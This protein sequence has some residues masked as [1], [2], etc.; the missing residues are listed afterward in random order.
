MLVGGR[1]RR[2][3]AGRG[4]PLHDDA[5]TVVGFS[6]AASRADLADAVAAARAA[7]PGWSGTSAH[8][9]GRLLF[10]VAEAL[11]ERRDRLATAAAV[12]ADDV[13]TAVD[14]WL[15]YA[16]W[17]DK[18]AGVVGAVHPVAGPYASWS[19]PQPVGVVG[20]LG[21]AALLGLVDGLA[22]VLAA[23]ATAVVV[24]PH[25]QPRAVADLAEV[26]A[27]AELPEGAAN[28]LTGDVAELAP[29]L[30]RAVDGLDLAGAPGESA[31]RLGR[32]AAARGIRVLPVAP[33]DPLA[34]L[35][36]WTDVTT[37]WQS[38]GR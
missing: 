9:R 11:D 2:A 28:L 34:R 1:L 19:T 10:A 12:P 8:E 18:L 7:L 5:G 24:A 36:A 17:T 38:V 22:S 35:R 29:E 13:G 26:L 3:E 37:V 32:D 33:A 25:D 14:R 21:P 4:R 23:G 6:T 31:A 20:V 16:G 27:T 15:W 30:A